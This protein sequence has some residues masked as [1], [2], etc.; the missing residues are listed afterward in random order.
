MQVVKLFLE[1][2]MLIP[3]PSLQTVAV[4]A[5]ME[6]PARAALLEAVVLKVAGAA[7][8]RNT[9]T[10]VVRPSSALA[11][12]RPA[13]YPLTAVVE[14]ST[15]RYAKEALSATAVPARDFAVL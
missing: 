5:S 1:P 14:M 4:G 3:V 10:L 7:S 15:A 8:R 13:R 11:T 9:A 6:N 12:A 2:A